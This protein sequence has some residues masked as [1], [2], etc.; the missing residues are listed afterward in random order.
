MDWLGRFRKPQEPES[1]PRA[2]DGSTSVPLERA[3]PGVAALFSG[4]PEGRTH[5]ILDFGSAVPANL[6]LYRRFAL[7]VRFGDLLADPPRGAALAEALDTL[8]PPPGRAFDLVL[9]WNLLDF[10]TPGERTHVMERLDDL[11]DPGARVY[12]LVDTSD[13]GTTQPFRFTL[14][15]PDRVKQEETG[16]PRPLP[17][18]LLPAEVER[19]LGP[20]EVFHGFTLRHGLREYVGVKHGQALRRSLWR[21]P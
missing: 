6:E 15:E 10:L 19:L 13:L 11:T 17:S 21:L 2:P 14:L 8:E 5:T 20:F 1:D 3:T 4:L 18:P 16:P 7:Q 12:V 9:I